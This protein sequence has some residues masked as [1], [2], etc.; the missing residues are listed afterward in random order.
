M[1]SIFVE[2]LNPT[3]FS[4]HGRGKIFFLDFISA[5]F[6]CSNVRVILVAMGVRL[7]NRAYNIHGECKSYD[8]SKHGQGE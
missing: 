1:Q 6:I 5:K 4:K 2:H 7:Q 3:F 8:F